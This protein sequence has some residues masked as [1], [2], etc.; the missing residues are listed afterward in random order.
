[1]T[2]CGLFVIMVYY[3]NECKA[4]IIK[5]IIPQNKPRGISPFLRAESFTNKSCNKIT[6]MTTKTQQN[7]ESGLERIEEIKKNICAPKSSEPCKAEVYE[8][9]D[10]IFESEEDEQ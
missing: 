1:M 9:W 5:G 4:P 10:G 7:T 6:K 2:S 8:M 3:Q